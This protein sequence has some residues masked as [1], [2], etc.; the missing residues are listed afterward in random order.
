[1]LALLDWELIIILSNSSIS[2]VIRNMAPQVGFQEIMATFIELDRLM[3]NYQSASWT[4]GNFKFIL[5]T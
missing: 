4:V 1:M 5:P 2:F 3:D